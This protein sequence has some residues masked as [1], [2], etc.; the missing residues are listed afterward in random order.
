MSLL[1][2]TSG[3]VAGYRRGSDS[4]AVVVPVNLE[5]SAGTFT[6]LLGANGAGKS[7]LMRTLA[8][9]QPPLAGTVRI[10]D[11]EI[12]SITPRERARMISLVYTERT[13]AGA[14]TV[15]ETVAL[16]RQ[17]HTGFFGRLDRDDRRAV[18]A[19]IEAMGLKK[20]AGR[21]VATLSDGERQKTMIARALAQ[22]TPVILLDEPT[23]FLD[24]A[25]RLDTMDMLDRLA[26]RDGKGI[27]LSTHDTGEALS[28]A[29]CAWLLPGD[30]R[31]V[32]GRV[33]TLSDDGSLASLFAGRG[34]TFDPV[35]RDFRLARG[36]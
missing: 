11:R 32:T 24:V 9:A 12:K 5:I 34:V 36:V 3:L 6:V 4:K 35:A 29:D 19:A 15:Y 27:L 25:S 10:C 17:P 16:G 14:L 8:G 1:L 28:V 33:D 26:H 23:A 13:L 2:H 20:L 21:H 18:D 7:T 31:V 22:A 30:G